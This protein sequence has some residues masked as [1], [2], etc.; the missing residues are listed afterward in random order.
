MFQAEMKDVIAAVVSTSGGVAA[1]QA[2]EGTYTAAVTCIGTSFSGQ[3]GTNQAICNSGYMVIMR[4]NGALVLRRS[5]GVP[6]APAARGMRATQPAFPRPDLGGQPPPLDRYEREREQLAAP[7]Q[8]VL[9]G[10]VTE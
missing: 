9:N 5:N 10:R 6:V 3:L 8:V 2:S 7:L 1:A 4:D